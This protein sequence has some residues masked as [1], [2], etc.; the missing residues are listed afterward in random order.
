MVVARNWQIEQILCGPCLLAPGF[1]QLCCC[2][3]DVPVQDV[4]NLAALLQRRFRPPCMLSPGLG[5]DA[6]VTNQSNGKSIWLILSAPTCKGAEYAHRP[7]TIFSRI[8]GATCPGSG[9]RPRVVPRTSDRYLEVP[10]QSVCSFV[11]FILPRHQTIYSAVLGP[12]TAN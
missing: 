12:T 10:L 4:S 7:P 8:I 6:E 2:F 3:P 1:S 11:H 5:S 9:T